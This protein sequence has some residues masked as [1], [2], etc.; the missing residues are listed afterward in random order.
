MQNLARRLRQEQDDDYQ[1]S[2]QAD[3]QKERER[4]AGQ[5][6]K[7]AERQAAEEVAAQ[8]RWSLLKIILQVILASN[9][10]YII[11]VLIILQHDKLNIMFLDCK[12]KTCSV[13]KRMSHEVYLCTGLSRSRKS[14]E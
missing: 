1:R 5:R 12:Y 7:D 11:L 8:E 6:Q 4:Q 13:M 3:M 9:Q 10:S 2:L 14:S